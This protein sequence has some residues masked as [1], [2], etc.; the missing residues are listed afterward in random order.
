MTDEASTDSPTDLPPGRRAFLSAVLAVVVGGHLFCLLSPWEDLWPF[1]RYA[2]YSQPR[3][4]DQ[5]EQYV[6]VGIDPE[7]PS[8]EIELSEHWEYLRPHYR[9]TLHASFRRLALAGDADQLRTAAEDCLLR[10]EQ[11]RRQKLHAGPELAG[12]RVYQYI[13]RYADVDRTTRRP[14]ERRLVVDVASVETGRPQ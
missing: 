3:D 14:T 10:Y 1:G 7:D 4:P 6:L 5:A 12:V 9:G 2:M 13:W 11:R 8:R